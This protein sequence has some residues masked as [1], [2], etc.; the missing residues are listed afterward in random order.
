[1]SVRRLDRGLG[2]GLGLGGLGF[3]RVEAGTQRVG[4]VTRGDGHRLDGFELFAGDEIEAADPVLGAVL[5]A[6]FGLTPHAGEGAGGAVHHLHEIVEQAVFGLHCDAPI[7]DFEA[8]GTS[9]GSETA[10][11]K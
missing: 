10:A 3:E 11:I 9:A 1:M 8:D 4:L 5:Q 6:R 7:S 2:R